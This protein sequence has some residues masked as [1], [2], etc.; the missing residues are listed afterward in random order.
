VTLDL[1][2]L[3]GLV[4]AALS[5]AMS[6]ALR[7]LVQVAGAAGGW[8]AARH[9]AGPVADGLARSV[10]APL[11]RAGASTLLF[12]GT[13][14]IV[15]LLGGLVLSATRVSRAVKGP[16]DRGV[17]AL[18]GGAKG[19]LAAGVLLSALA[20]AQGA[21]PGRLAA[22]VEQSELAALARSHNLLA[23]LAPGPAGAIE[24]LKQR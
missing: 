13:L 5:G 18:L 6:G 1:V 21:L 17:G 14:A 12:L 11:A 24:K 2:V 16:V 20:L 8:L 4:L 9:L 23:R 22:P 7:Q 15:T 3:A 10:P 19:I